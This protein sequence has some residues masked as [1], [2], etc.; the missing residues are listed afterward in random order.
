MS[1]DSVIS[2]AMLYDLETQFLQQRALDLQHFLKHIEEET[3]EDSNILVSHDWRDIPHL[4][5]YECEAQIIKT[6]LDNPDRKDAKLGEMLGGQLRKLNNQQM[7]L[8]GGPHNYSDAYWKNEL[9]RTVVTKILD[10][11]WDWL[12]LNG[13]TDDAG[14]L[15][16][17]TD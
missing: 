5:P 16:H 17:T 8:M 1:S 14:G 9:E 12:L 11:W 13:E 3:G 2:N 4:E 7:K 6:Y 10:D 15:A